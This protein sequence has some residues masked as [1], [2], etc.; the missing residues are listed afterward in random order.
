M[1]RKYPS[2]Y[3]INKDGSHKDV[4]AAQYIAELICEKRAASMNRELPT[5]FWELEEWAKYYKYQIML[6]YKLLKQFSDKAIVKGLFDPK[7]HN[8]FSLNNPWLKSIIHKYNELKEPEV[9]H[10]DKIDPV[11]KPIRQQK[12]NIISRLNEYDVERD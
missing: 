1:K 8:V 10:I 11:A 7:C 4:T 5:K 12:E 9:K 2:R 6:A 3:S